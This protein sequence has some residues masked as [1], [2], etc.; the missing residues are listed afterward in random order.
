VDG[1]ASYE[2]SVTVSIETSEVFTGLPS[3]YPL[4]HH[5]GP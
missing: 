1:S 5:N 2:Q 4:H 3:C